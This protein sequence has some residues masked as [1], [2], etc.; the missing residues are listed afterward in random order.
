MVS[1][2][3]LRDTKHIFNEEANASGTPMVTTLPR[4][5]EGLRE[6]ES[7]LSSPCGYKVPKALPMLFSF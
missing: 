3:M 2:S 1:V 4:V 5:T 6:H 7:P